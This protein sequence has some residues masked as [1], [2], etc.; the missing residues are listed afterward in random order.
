MLK[1]HV[2]VNRQ[3]IVLSYST[4][5]QFPKVEGRLSCVEISGKELQAFLVRNGTPVVSNDGMVISWHGKHAGRALRSMRE[6]FDT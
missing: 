1:I 4:G 5:Q 6:L 2:N 3:D